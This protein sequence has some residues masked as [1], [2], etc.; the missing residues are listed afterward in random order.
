MHKRSELQCPPPKAGGTSM[1]PCAP[2]PA[3]KLLALV[4]SKKE[5]VAAQRVFDLEKYLRTAF[6]TE[7]LAEYWSQKL[8]RCVHGC[9]HWPHTPPPLTCSITHCGHLASDL[10]RHPPAISFHATTILATSTC[11]QD[12]LV[13]V[14]GFMY[15]ANADRSLGSHPGCCR[16][17]KPLPA[18][19]V[20]S[21]I[22]H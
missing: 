17:M 2:F 20:R 8:L 10:L 12:V 11:T 6:K 7:I 15:R 13:H 22:Q 19:V 5:K 1:R 3:K 14:V 21:L 18:S 9:S 16:S 4:K